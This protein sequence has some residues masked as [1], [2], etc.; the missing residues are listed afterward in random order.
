MHRSCIKQSR[1]STDLSLE[2][3]EQKAKE[4]NAEGI[5]QQVLQLPSY[6]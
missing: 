6:K 1:H 5:E 4:E 3:K 2:P